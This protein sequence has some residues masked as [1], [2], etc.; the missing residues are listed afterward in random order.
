M[1]ISTDARDLADEKHLCE[2]GRGERV[3]DV[4]RMRKGIRDLTV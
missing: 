1:L 4:S 2:G 3:N